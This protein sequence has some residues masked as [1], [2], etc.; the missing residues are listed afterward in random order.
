[1]AS[2]VPF[3]TIEIRPSCEVTLFLS[4]FFS[5]FVFLIFFLLLWEHILGG[6]ESGAGE[7]NWACGDI[8]RLHQIP[9]QMAFMNPSHR[10]GK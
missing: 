10:L 2:N 6:L 9:D 5:L 4:S 3:V 1:M 8:G 7:E